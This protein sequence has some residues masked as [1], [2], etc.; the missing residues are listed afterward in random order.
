MK[1]CHDLTI[2]RKG[3]VTCF[4]ECTVQVMFALATAEYTCCT[5][6]HAFKKYNKDIYLSV[7]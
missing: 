2:K 3:V 1:G 4:G 7:V 5:W 6:G